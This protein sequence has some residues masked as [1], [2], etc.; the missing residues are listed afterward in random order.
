[1]IYIYYSPAQLQQSIAVVIFVVYVYKF[2]FLFSFSSFFSTD[3][4]RCNMYELKI[5]NEQHTQ[6]SNIYTCL[7]TRHVCHV[8]FAHRSFVTWLLQTARL[9]GDFCTR[10]VFHVFCTRYVVLH[11]IRCF[12]L[13][14]F[15][16]W[17]SLCSKSL[18][19]FSETY[20]MFLI[21]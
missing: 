8:T 18:E 14:L 2:F 21:W 15:R 13:G 10:Q 11:T 4:F 16:V 7:C 1:M 5:V 6:C 9:S 12:A 17:T 3:V 19:V 20:I